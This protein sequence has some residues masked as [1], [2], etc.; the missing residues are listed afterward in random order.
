MERLFTALTALRD[1]R[2][3]R[4]GNWLR[5]DWSE[6][7]LTVKVVVLVGTPL[8]SRLWRGTGSSSQSART[9]FEVSAG[10]APLDG[11]GG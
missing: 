10:V 7:S 3:G 6:D 8:T 1:E 4:T 2:A 9:G 5:L 11:N